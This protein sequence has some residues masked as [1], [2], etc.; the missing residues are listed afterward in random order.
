MLHALG[1]AGGNSRLVRR[2]QR[3]TKAQRDYD[4]A[5]AVVCGALGVLAGLANL[6]VPGSLDVAAKVL[7]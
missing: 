4:L 6:L 3:E 5:I 1:T 2:V 7:G